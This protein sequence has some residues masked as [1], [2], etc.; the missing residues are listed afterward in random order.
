[1]TELAPLPGTREWDEERKTVIGGTEVPPVIGLSQEDCFGTKLTVYRSKTWVDNPPPFKESLRMKRGSDYEPLVAQSFAEDYG[2]EVEHHTPM[3]KCK[4]LDCLGVHLDYLGQDPTGAF[5]DG[6]KGVLEIKNVWPGGGVEDWGSGGDFRSEF[7]HVHDLRVPIKY[8]VQLQTQLLCSE[9]P[10]GL[11]VMRPHFGNLI[12]RVFGPFLPDLKL[13]DLILSKVEAFWNDHVIPR[14]P[15]PPAMGE[16]G[17]YYMNPTTGSREATE[18]EMALFS[19]LLKAKAMKDKGSDLFDRCK[20][21][22]QRS[23]GND[24]DKLKGP[25]GRTIIDWKLNKGGKRPF[26]LN[27]SYNEGEDQ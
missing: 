15:P 23:M 18:R 3:V 5:M 6:S 14:I 16:E 27:Y 20:A 4:K 1:M 19:S 22:L 24:F 26:N 11:I 25:T 17:K 21:M 10:W 13:H 8:Y 12:D 2:F 7:E 9:L